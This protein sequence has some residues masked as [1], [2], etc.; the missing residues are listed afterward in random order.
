VVVGIIAIVILYYL[1]GM[2]AVTTY[3]RDRRRRRVQ[4]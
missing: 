4:G 1:V 3:F 2:V